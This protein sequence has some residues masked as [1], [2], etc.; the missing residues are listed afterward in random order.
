MAFKLRTESKELSVL[1]SLHLR[2]ELPAKDA[3]NLYKLEKGF[4]GERKFDEF[5]DGLPGSWLTLNDLQLESNRT[6]FQND[7]TLIFQGTIHL[8]NV[9]NNH[10][11]YYIDKNGEWYSGTEKLTKDPFMQLNRSENL[12][13]QLLQEQGYKIPI[14]SYLVFINPEFYLYNAPRNMPAIFPTQL[15]RYKNKLL[16]IPC[17]LNEGHIK[18][19]K[20]LVTLHQAES[21]YTRYPEYHYGKLKMGM[22]CDICHSFFTHFERSIL[23]CDHC[24]CIEDIET[25]VLRCVD[26]LLLLFPERKITVTNVQQWCDI[27]SKKTVRRILSKYFKEA[28]HSCA[29]YYIKE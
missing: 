26:E 2:M 27:I 4:E 28:G 19:A 7:T 11:D 21:P 8:I 25:A 13:K 23:I 24:G 10:G 17:E 15:N 14:E 20:K 9:K 29:T 1:R 12:L 3:I 6:S 5:I 16:S 22:I 18:L